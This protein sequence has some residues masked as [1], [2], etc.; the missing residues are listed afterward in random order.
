MAMYGIVGTPGSGKSLFAVQRI[1]IEFLHYCEQI[2][3]YREI[4]HN[5]EGLNISYLL[6]LANMSEKE[7]FWR[8]HFHALDVD[9]NG[10]KDDFTPRYFWLK[11]GTTTTTSYIDSTDNNKVKYKVEGEQIENGS[12][13]ILDEVQNI[14]S[15]RNTLSAASDQ[16]KSFLTK[17]RHFKITLYWLTQNQ[18]AVDVSFRRNTEQIW[19]LERL[20]NIAFTKAGKQKAIV[21]KYLGW[22]NMDALLPFAIEKF[23]YDPKFF[24][25]YDSYIKGTEK[26][27]EEVRKTTNMFLQSKGL[28]IVAVLLIVC[29]AFALYMGNPL[30]NMVKGMEAQAS[31]RLP[32]SPPG[33]SPGGGGEPR[34]K[35]EAPKPKKECYTN[36][37][38]RNGLLIYYKNNE[39]INYKPGVEY[40]KCE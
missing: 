2:K 4:Y 5:L 12:L 18:E 16:S 33:F 14:Y 31:P 24:R 30:T 38:V 28:R 36:Y 25:A 34:I 40:E 11:R 35:S 29:I 15:A 26:L 6:E 37:V 32:A 20:E 22:D 39:Q 7:P 13:V 9:E 19:K 3:Q 8:E 1:L 17:H 23:V 27:G 10:E 21:K